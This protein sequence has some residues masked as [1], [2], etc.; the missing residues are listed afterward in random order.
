MTVETFLYVLRCYGALNLPPSTEGYQ[1]PVPEN[2][3]HTPIPLKQFEWTLNLLTRSL[4]LW[5]QAY[6]TD[7]LTSLAETLLKLGMDP[8]GV[9]LLKPI[10]DS[11]EA[12]FMALPDGSWKDSTQKLALHLCGKAPLELQVRFIRILKPT[13]PRSTYFRRVAAVFAL[14]M[15]LHQDH[16]ETFD[17]QA[18][19]SLLDSGT[20][21]PHLVSTLGNPRHLFH[22]NNPDYRR[23]SNCVYLL[24]Y[25]IGT[26]PLE[27]AENSVRSYKQGG[28][29]EQCK[30]HNT[31]CF[32]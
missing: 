5:P 17:D 32:Y 9:V 8:I 20:L 6:R 7:E 14:E 30:C 16:Q 29:T 27:L 2:Q 3:R 10:Q 1:Q 11:L 31:F 22:R 21:F 26:A 13:C 12:G 28:G 25:T 19:G 23:L 4:G 24:D 15:A 18:L